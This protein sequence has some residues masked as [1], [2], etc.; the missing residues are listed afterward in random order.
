MSVSVIIPTYNRAELVQETIDSVLRQTY[1][2]YEIIVIDDG[3]TDDTEHK[4]KRYGNDINYI[5]QNNKGLNAAR[6]R[7]LDIASG[8]YIALLDSDDLWLDFKLEL[9]TSLLNQYST[10]AFAFSDFYILKPDN[11][12]IPNGLHSWYHETPD[13]RNIFA[14]KNKCQLGFKSKDLYKKTAADI[15][16]GD[17][18]YVSLFG[19]RVLPSASLFR[20]SMVDGFFRFNENNTA[21]GDWEF[22]AKLS[23]KHRALF[24]D[25]ETALNRSHDDA[26]RLTRLDHKV[27]LS[28]RIA[29]IDQT[30][31]KDIEFYKQHKQEVDEEQAR[32]Y[33]QVLKYQLIEGNK[34]GAK[35]SLREIQG[36]NA[37]SAHRDLLVY[38]IMAHTPGS[39][40]I[41]NFL[42]AFIKIIFQSRKQK[43]HS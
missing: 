35:R 28:Q 4:L 26:V 11:R 3:S 18:Y 8:E 25:M 1:K 21:C 34:Q 41:L 23:H 31:K 2:D 36:I 24:I 29:L 13:W 16:F 14:S 37:P 19:P 42:R 30:W 32:I 9:E 7:A 5:K 12:R 33:K 10:C 15:Y 6:N 43:K 17:I 38:K 27:Q 40:F 39:G 22:F 20:K